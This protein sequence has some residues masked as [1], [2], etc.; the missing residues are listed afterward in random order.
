MKTAPFASTYSVKHKCLKKLQIK[1]H[2]FAEITYKMQTEK[3]NYSE[4][5][6]TRNQRAK[7]DAYTSRSPHGVALI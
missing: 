5:A 7:S 3:G 1:W 6:G 2:N 4:T